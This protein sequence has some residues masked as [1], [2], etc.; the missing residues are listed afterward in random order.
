QATDSDGDAGNS[1]SQSVSIANVAPTV[2]LTS[3]PASANE[4]QTKTYSYSISD[5][6]LDTVSSVATSCGANGTKSNASNTNTSGSFDC[7]FP[8]RPASST[9]SAQATDSDGDAGNTASQTVTIAKVARTASRERL[10]DLS[11]NEGSPHTYAYTI[12]DPGQDTVSSV[13]TS[14][15]TSGFKSNDSHTN[16]AGSFDCTF[17]DGPNSSSVSPQA[18]DSDGDAGNTASQTV[19]IA[20][21]APTVTL[22]GPAA[23]SSEST[24][25]YTINVSDAGDDNTVRSS[26]R[27]SGANCTES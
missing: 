9:V 8:D 17:P 26:G 13:A 14:C 16:S 25:T 22:A 12:S 1:A 10:N 27:S 6:G 20:N 4:G 18:T 19:T 5:P 23:V 2:A 11:V 3:A 15:G 7:S 21:V 24:Q